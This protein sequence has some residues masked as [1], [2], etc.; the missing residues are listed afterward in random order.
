MTTGELL[1]FRFY[2]PRGTFLYTER[3][4][5]NYHCAIHYP[6]HMGNI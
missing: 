2:V 6:V 4:L 3:I 5:N 1:F